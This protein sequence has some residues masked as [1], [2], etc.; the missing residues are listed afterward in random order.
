MRRS[1]AY[2]ASLIVIAAATLLGRPSFAQTAAAQA[3]P[4]AGGG[5]SAEVGEVVVVARRI[6]ERLQDVPLTVSVANQQT[7][8]Q[9][10]VDEGADLIKLVP[11]LNVEIQS[12]F[13][14]A[15]YA[16]RGIRDGVVSYFNEVPLKN[17]TQATD[18]QLWDLGSI[19][20]L[21]GPQGTLFGQNATGGAILFLPQRPTQTFGGYVD[22]SYGNFNHEQLTAVLNLPV[23]DM[24]Q[25]RLGYHLNKH[26]PF[27][28][29]IGTG[30]S[31][32]SENRNAF[33]F[34]ALFSPTPTITNYTVFDY[35]HR[36]EK[37]SALISEFLT[38]VPGPSGNYWAEF[39][40]PTLLPMQQA[41]Q[42]ALGIRTIDTP[43]SA[44]D[45]ATNYGVSNIFTDSLT[46]NLTLKYIFGY[47]AWSFNES[48]SDSSY[49]VPIELGRDTTDGASQYT[50][51]VQLLGK[52][53]DG[54]LSW[55]AGYFTSQSTIP[56]VS[57]F[58]L[59]GEPG[60]PFSPSV[61]VY[62]PSVAKS[63]T[64]AGYVQASF[65][66]TSKLNITAGVR[67]T[68][69]TASSVSSTHEPAKFFT[70]TIGSS[71]TVCGL[72]PTQPGVDYAACTQSQSLAENAVTY[73][74]SVD[75]HFS[76]GVMVYATTRNGYNVGGFNP[77]APA[78][79]PPGAP[80][81]VFKPE[82]VTD[83]E[84]GAK[85][86][87]K[88]GDMPYRADLSGY[89]VNYTDIQQS[90][91]GFDPA[92]YSGTGNGPKAQIYGFQLESAFEPIHGLNLSVNYGYL[93]TGYTQGAPGFEQ[94]N[95]F[96]QAPEHTINL[97]GTYHHPLP[98][99]GAFM[100]SL[101]WSYQ[102]R[103]T[104][105]NNQSSFIQFTPGGPE[106]AVP[107]LHAFQPAYGI[108]DGEIGWE[109]VFNSPV[110]VILFV[111][112]LTNASYAVQVQDQTALLG[113][114]GVVYDDPRTFGVKL[115]YRF[116]S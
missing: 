18:D 88:L 102:S 2:Q 24:L 35:G 63:G 109:S 85:L 6:N 22:A 16:I 23:N 110:D 71:P 27:V 68:A 87:G 94:G 49:S 113:F 29:N 105:Q 60:Q 46:S 75:Y 108:A 12:N 79:P 17:D 66:A 72:S 55:T 114:T 53:F 101:D 86:Q 20:A 40:A 92:P 28:N 26:D 69:N 82:F 3:A 11:T 33:R 112:N 76:P 97:S 61:D 73:S 115:H 96:G 37:P 99:G 84:L 4:P 51:E 106:V 54:R 111:K 1:H 91:F 34:S 74:L 90:Q 10:Q 8:K 77:S 36:D 31:R 67:Y 78:N 25:L 56:L 50:H 39:Y 41:R 65:A 104:F 62:E 19:Q 107:L 83:Y 38:P 9:I 70:A 81:P 100:A 58:Q 47:R 30:D 21:A 98:A 13:P 80:G 64:Q 44:T 48:S 42:D 7:L 52:L 89:F 103:I 116:G 43:Y 93:H 14:G 15:T 59:Y 32:Q 57:D 95:S 45:T 5:A